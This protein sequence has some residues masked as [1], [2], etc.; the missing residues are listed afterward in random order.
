[1]AVF[2]TDEDPMLQDQKAVAVQQK[3]AQE[4]DQKMLEIARMQELLYEQQQQQVEDEE[5]DFDFDLPSGGYDPSA[6]GPNSSFAVPADS[7]G[8]AY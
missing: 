7:V 5:Y 6:E 1:M 3:Y 8:A 4:L 2:S